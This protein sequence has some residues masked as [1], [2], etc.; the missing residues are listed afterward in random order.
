TPP[1]AIAPTASSSKPGTPS[2]RTIKTSSGTRSACATSYATGTPPRGKPRTIT[3]SRPAYFESFKPSIRPASARFGKIPSMSAITVCPE[4]VQSAERL[5]QS[6]PSLQDNRESRLQT[7]HDAATTKFSRPVDGS[8]LECK[9]PNLAT[10][11]DQAC[12]GAPGT[13]HSRKA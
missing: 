12:P 1:E 13:R 8:R 7:F 5:R 4:S 9:D 10:V 2:L 11:R 6:A 3:S